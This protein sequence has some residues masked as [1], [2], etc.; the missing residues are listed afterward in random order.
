M[1]LKKRR[2]LSVEQDMMKINETG[3]GCLLLVKS[4]MMFRNDSKSQVR[5]CMIVDRNDGDQ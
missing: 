5:E 2:L 1:K 4:K 3:Q